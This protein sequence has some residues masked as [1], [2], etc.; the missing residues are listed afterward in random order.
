MISSASS[1]LVFK[2]NQNADCNSEYRDLV[3]LTRPFHSVKVTF[4]PPPTPKKKDSASRAKA[5]DS[6]FVIPI[7]YHYFESLLFL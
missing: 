2:I 4:P 1:S 5:G 3:P 7:L 6:I